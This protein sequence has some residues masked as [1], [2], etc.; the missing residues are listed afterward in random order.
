MP[1]VTS[2]TPAQKA[3]LDAIVKQMKAEN[4][5]SVFT[6]AAIL[7]IVSKETEFKWQA[8]KGYGNTDNARIRQIF[9]NRVSSY[10]EEQLTALKK[11]EEKFFNVIYGGRFGN[12]ATE[13]Y[14]FRGRGPNQTTFKGNY[15]KIGKDIGVDLVT[16]PD[17]INEPDTAAKSV[18][19]YFRNAFKGMPAPIKTIYKLTGN[20]NDP[21]D[22]DTAVMAIYHANAG[23]GKSVEAIKAD[24][25]GGLKKAQT[26][27]PEFLT[28]VQANV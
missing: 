3:N 6:R 23:F 28:Y 18:I 11:D 24:P 26:R 21:T 15:D 16:N 9:G 22:L 19:S 7:A 10:T 13:G 17:K 2:L 8:E 4:I 12:S 25:T 20:L 1:Y 14:K 27:A 5:T